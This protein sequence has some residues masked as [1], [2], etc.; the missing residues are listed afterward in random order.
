VV[1]APK[2]AITGPEVASAPL[3]ASGAGPALS[4][5]D[6]EGGRD[7]QAAAER[8]ARA[9]PAEVAAAREMQQPSLRESVAKRAGE[10]ADT[11]EKELERIARL[12]SEG[13]HEEADKALAEFRKR[14]P[15]FRIPEPMLERVERR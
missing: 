3:P 2:A 6:R 8:A 12:R 14:H 7:R 9:A 4:R 13:R 5:S 11:P 1:A 10:A 15:D